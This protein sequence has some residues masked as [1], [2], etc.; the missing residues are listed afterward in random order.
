MFWGM[1]TVFTTSN[2]RF[3]LANPALVM[4]ILSIKLLLPPGYSGCLA[5]RQYPADRLPHEV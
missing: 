1:E 2:S 3:N 5:G 4:G